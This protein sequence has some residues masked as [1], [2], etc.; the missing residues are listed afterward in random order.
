MSAGGDL[1]HAHSVQGQPMDI[2]AD[3]EVLN[4]FSRCGA[5]KTG[6]P[7]MLSQT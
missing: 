7:H 6:V 3:H 5:R 4:P 1:E 2:T